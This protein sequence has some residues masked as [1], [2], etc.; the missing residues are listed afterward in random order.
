M[1]RNDRGL[2]SATSARVAQAARDSARELTEQGIQFALI[3]GLAVN[4][5]GR[6]RATTDVDYIVP[7]DAQEH[8]GVGG[9]LSRRLGVVT[10]DYD[11]ISVD[12]LLVRDLFLLAELDTPVMVEGFPVVSVEALVYL[13]LIANRNRD[14]RDII[15]LIESGINT[16]SVKAYLGENAPSLVEDF[17]Q[18]VAIARMDRR[19]KH[20]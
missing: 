3:G 20:R 13:K 17:E 19:G 9:A 7:R 1:V 15:D 6:P 4:A 18:V 8:L 5:H 12:C 10:L 16:E 2:F 11:G 14:E